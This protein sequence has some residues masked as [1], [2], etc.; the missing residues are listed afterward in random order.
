M[1]TLENARNVLEGL[2]TIQYTIYNYDEFI[3]ILKKRLWKFTGKT[4]ALFFNEKEIVLEMGRLGVLQ[5]LSGL[6]NRAG[7]K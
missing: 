2:R 6:N 4:E 7:S 1:I 3:K 5:D